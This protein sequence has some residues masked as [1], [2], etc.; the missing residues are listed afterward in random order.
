MEAQPEFPPSIC[1]KHPHYQS[2][3]FLG[4][5]KSHVQRPA[6]HRKSQLSF[7]LLSN[8]QSIAIRSHAS[9]QTGLKNPSQDPNQDENSARDDLWCI[10][11]SVLSRV[12]VYLN[13][14]VHACTLVHNLSSDDQSKK[15]DV[16][17]PIFG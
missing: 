12:I 17:F 14:N 11:P 2:P 4:L 10:V 16:A 6:S 13:P 3:T 8:A 5:D 9:E 1:P 7:F 15:P